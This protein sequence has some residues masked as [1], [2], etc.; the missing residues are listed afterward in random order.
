MTKTELKDIIEKILILCSLH[1]I[2]ESALQCLL[3]DCNFFQKCF[4]CQKIWAA[5]FSFYLLFLV[6]PA[7]YPSV[8]PIPLQF[9]IEIIKTWLALCQTWAVI[10]LRVCV[11]LLSAILMTYCGASQFNVTT[12]RCGWSVGTKGP[13]PP[14]KLKLGAKLGFVPYT[15]LVY[16]LPLKFHIPFLL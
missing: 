3:Q 7:M 9:L 1:L 16:F 12:L 10:N 14:H 15:N 4:S 2:Y 6:F 11:P 13:W 8:I 5:K